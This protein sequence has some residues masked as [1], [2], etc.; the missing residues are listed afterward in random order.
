MT[1]PIVLRPRCRRASSTARAGLDAEI[2]RRDRGQRAV[3]VGERRAHAVEQPGVGQGGGD[4]RR[5]CCM[6]ASLSMVITR[7]ER[8]HRRKVVDQRGAMRQHGALVDRALVGDLADIERRR[9]GQQRS[10][11]STRV[12]EP[13]DG[14]RE[15]RRA[16]RLNSSR[17]PRD[18]PARR[19]AAR[20]RQFGRKLAAGLDVGQHQ[21]RDVVAVGAGDHH[22]AHIAARS[23]R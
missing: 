4:A 14:R 9:L 19:A 23:A 7:G 18:R 1:V 22:V 5:S 16:G 11:A 12:E 10:R 2:D 15:A 21:R 8:R 20:R 3:V 13:V 17:T 6:Q